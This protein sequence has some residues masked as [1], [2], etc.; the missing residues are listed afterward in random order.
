MRYVVQIFQTIVTAAV[1]ERG[2]A[3]G[4]SE[5]QFKIGSIEVSDANEARALRKANTFGDYSAIVLFRV[6]TG[7]KSILLTED[8]M[9]T[10]AEEYQRNLAEPS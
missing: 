4:K 3:K 10:I 6:Y 2:I 9:Q 5:R 7:S 8:D 1:V